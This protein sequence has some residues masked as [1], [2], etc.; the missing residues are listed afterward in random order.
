MTFN[1]YTNYEQL[2]YI[3]EWYNMYILPNDLIICASIKDGT[4]NCEKYNFSVGL[5]YEYSNFNENNKINIQIGKHSNLVFNC[6]SEHTDNYRRGNSTINRKIIS[7]NLK[8][9]GITNEIVN[10]KK[11]SVLEYYNK[12]KEHKFVI[13]PEG[14]GIDCHRHYEAILCGCIPIIEDNY[15]MRHKYKNTPVLFT[16]DYSEITTE[17]LNSKYNEIIKDKYNY[18]TLVLQNHSIEDQTLIKENGNYWSKKR[19]NKIA[20]HL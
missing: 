15:Y 10:S 14:N 20:Y 12:L 11:Y 9:N 13:S 6:F 5:H 7:K 2:Y 8:K 4:D 1:L 3:Q 18:S 16:K 19:I 17:Y